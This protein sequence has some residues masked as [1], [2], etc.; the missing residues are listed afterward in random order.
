MSH[1]TVQPLKLQES[2]DGPKNNSTSPLWKQ[3]LQKSYTGSEGGCGLRAILGVLR[4]GSVK[5]GSTDGGNP[6]LQKNKST[7]QIAAKFAVHG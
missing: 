2:F 1:A 7:V 6:G 3:L 5:D 4:E